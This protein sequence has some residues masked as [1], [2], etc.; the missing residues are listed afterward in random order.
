MSVRH[1]VFFCV[2]YTFSSLNCYASDVKEDFV[3]DRDCP[4]LCTCAEYDVNCTN[5]NVFPDS[6]PEETKRFFLINSTIDFVPI[7]AF[8][9]LPKLKE[10][11]FID[12]KATKLRACSFAELENMSVISF[13]RTKIEQI[14]GNAFSNL[15]NISN[16]IFSGATIGE[17]FSFSFHNVKYVK[18]LEFFQATISTVHPLA[19]LTFENIGE[20]GIMDSTVQRFLKNGF[21]GF[22]NVELIYMTNSEI[23]EWQCGSLDTVL[24]SG[25][26]FD[27]SLSRF[28]CDC[29]LAWL[30]TK[31]LNS[32]ILENRS[33]KC[34]GT[35][36]ALPSINVDQ[37]CPSE[38]SRDQGCPPLLPST[39]H[40]CS[41]NF[42]SPMNPVEK[43]TY[44][45]FFSR[46][47]TSSTSS[48]TTVNFKICFIMLLIT[49][50]HCLI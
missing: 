33:N 12:S 25:I 48:V 36:T 23:T 14:E 50:Y 1:I 6:I 19:L 30:W 18:R 2:I 15:V 28:A 35:D 49:C 32:T 22:R 3:S 8:L 27:V 47:T 9:D 45:N 41:R 39:P 17:L 38:K 43:V 46:I 44:P 34:T 20:I 11:H 37:I 42:D 26:D 21:S 16:I 4:F 5:T 24:K 29:K 7:N 40:T 10:I 31:H 13:E